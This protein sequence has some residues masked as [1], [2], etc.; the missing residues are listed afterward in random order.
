MKDF[1]A[2]YNI[3]LPFPIRGLDILETLPCDYVQII[4]TDALRG[5][6]GY[7]WLSGS[8]PLPWE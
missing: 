2:V 8:F 1:I 7:P 3:H 5:I 6:V 4:E